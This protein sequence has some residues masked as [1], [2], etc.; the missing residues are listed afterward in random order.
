M[1]RMTDWEGEWVCKC[2]MQFRAHQGDF[3]IFESTPCSS[4]RF[5]T[6]GFSDLC[7]KCGG[8]LGSDGPGDQVEYRVGRFNKV[9]TKNE[10]YVW[11][12]PLT[13]PKNIV[14]YEHEVLGDDN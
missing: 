2:G 9:V 10:S 4:S 12:K 11:W 5:L 3:A 6:F 1:T 7:K 8:N 13:W 14:T